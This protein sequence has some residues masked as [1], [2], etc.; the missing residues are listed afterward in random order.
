MSVAV[1]DFEKSFVSTGDLSAAE[2]VIVKI[3]TTVDQNVVIA[4]AATDPII[5]V[6]QNKPKAGEPAVVRW[7]GS[8][9]VIAGGTIT[10]GDC[11]TSDGSGHAITTTTTGNVILGRALQSAVSGDIFEVALSGPFSF[12][13]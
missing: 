12:H 7:G 11:V 3:S 13:L 10:A 6:L 8:T 1:R 4:A 5:G 2:F 9:K